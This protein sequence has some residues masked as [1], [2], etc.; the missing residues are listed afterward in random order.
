ME[1][2]EKKKDKT[3]KAPAKAPKE[4]KRTGG[5]V[6]RAEK[7]DRYVAKYGLAAPKDVASIVYR[8]TSSLPVTEEKIG[9]IS[10]IDEDAI[11]LET[12]IGQQNGSIKIELDRVVSFEGGLGKA[13]S[14][15]V[16][17][18]KE[19]GEPVVGTIVKPKDAL[20]NFI[21]VRTDDKL[22]VGFNR[23]QSLVTIVREKV[24]VSK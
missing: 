23:K 4:E 11:T 24:K 21:Y 6:G 22:V 5:K 16:K 15:T 3:V 13:S 8:V 14:V 18:F 10:L 7:L 19:V 20:P 9:I 17:T 2:L 1:Y 12:R